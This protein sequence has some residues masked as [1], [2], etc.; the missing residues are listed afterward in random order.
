M[1]ADCVN[2]IVS[3]KISGSD[4]LSVTMYGRPVRCKSCLQASVT[5]RSVI[6]IRQKEERAVRTVRGV[7]DCKRKRRPRDKYSRLKNHMCVKEC[8]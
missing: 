1:F 2:P 8:S 7:E 5:D 3:I 6:T 4:L